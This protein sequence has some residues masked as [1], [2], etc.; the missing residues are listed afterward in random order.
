MDENRINEF[1]EAM[2]KLGKFRQHFAPKDHE[3]SQLEF[4]VLFMIDL[5]KKEN[6]KDFVTVSE[7]KER[8]NMTNSAISQVLNVLENKDYISRSI[9]KTDRRYVYIYMS[10]KGDITIS[11]ERKRVIS[12]FTH[13]VNIYGEENFEKLIHLINEFTH[14]IEKTEKE[15][16]K[17]ID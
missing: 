1:F 10:E 15:G 16:V 6:L 11:E 17:D 4:W 12:Y 9:S 8:V 2:K 5:A 7:I 3:L 13:I 14:V